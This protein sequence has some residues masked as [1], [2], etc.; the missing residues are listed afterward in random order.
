MNSVSGM[1]FHC[2]L[3]LGVSDFFCTD[4]C[5]LSILCRCFLALLNH[6]SCWL[7]RS[8]HSSCMLAR[9]NHKQ[10]QLHYF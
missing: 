10:D 5:I 3:F 6:S 4:S 8:L 7:L 1:G 9:K 2:V